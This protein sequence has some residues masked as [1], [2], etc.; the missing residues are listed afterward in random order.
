[1]RKLAAALCLL[2]C[3]F[4]NTIAS[5]AIIL[6]YDGGV[7]NY[8]GNVYSLSV[9]GKTLTDLPLEPIIF[10]NRALVPVREIFEELGATVDYEQSDKSVTVSYG[11][12]KVWLKIDS[13]T[14]NVDGTSVTITDNVAPKL[15]AKWGESAKTMVP[16]R[17]IS[18]NIGLKVDFDDK[19]GHISISDGNARPTKSP[20]PSQDVKINDISATYDG[21]VVTVT[22]SANGNIEKISK[23][24]ATASGVIFAD[25]YGVKYLTDNKVQIDLDCVKSV[26]VGLHEGYTRVAID[27][28]NMKKYSAALSA[29]K[30]AVVFKLSSNEDADVEPD[31]V[32]STPSQTVKPSPTVPPSPTETPSSTGTPPVSSTPAPTKTPS[33]ATSKKPI[34]YNSEKIVIIDAGHGGSDPGAQ[35][36]LMNAEEMAAYKAALETTTPIIATM[37]PG[38]AGEHNEKDIALKIAHKVKENLEANGIKTIMTREGDTYPELYERPELANSVGAVIFVSIHLNS[39]VTEVTAANGIEVYYS[40]KNNDDDIGLTSKQL[41]NLLLEKIIDSTNARS[42]GVKT[43]NLLVNRE[44][45]MP[46]ALVEVGFINNPIELEKM[47]SESYQAKLAAGISQGIIAAWNKVELPEEKTEDSKAK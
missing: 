30:K 44:C 22:I 25:V 35:G 34:K 33:P 41:S 32:V 36:D 46:S 17:F 12:R 42:R 19:T 31:T 24:S 15:I 4:V 3:I 26:R 29:D 37:K 27:T 5:A 13:T 10:N 18:E 2:C 20:S 14:A 8:T 9:N 23:A 39:S 38:S 11:K 7:H 16:V 21:D 6:E 43:G 1:M 45:L 47:I 40:E 28:E